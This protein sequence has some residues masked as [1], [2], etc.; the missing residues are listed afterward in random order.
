M[1]GTPIVASAIPKFGNSEVRKVS[2]KA[3]PPDGSTRSGLRERQSRF[4]VYPAS[5]SGSLRQAP[6]GSPRIPV[7][8]KRGPHQPQAA[9][10]RDPLDGY[11]PISRE[12]QT[13]RFSPAV[14]RLRRSATFFRGA[15]A[16]TSDLVGSSGFDSFARASGGHWLLAC[17]V[18]A[19]SSHTIGSGP[20]FNSTGFADERTEP[21]G[22]CRRSV[23]KALIALRY[24]VW[25]AP[26]RFSAKPACLIVASLAFA[27]AMSA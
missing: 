20:Q 11:I 10:D 4:V 22:K 19:A 3:T 26:A 24:R 7:S 27:T 16:S 6:V 25:A 23:V 2:R 5:V 9:R 1:S 8:L 15:N 18:N 14:R 13:P 21:D 17:V 12:I